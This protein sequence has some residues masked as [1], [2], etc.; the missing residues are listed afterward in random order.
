MLTNCINV[1]VL[2]RFFSFYT[3]VGRA[4]MLLGARAAF[5][6]I[7]SYETPTTVDT[8]NIHLALSQLIENHKEVASQCIPA[9]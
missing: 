4:V 5:L 7:S 3:L 2:C 8:L 6:A 9:H 1:G